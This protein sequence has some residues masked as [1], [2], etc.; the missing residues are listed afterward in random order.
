MPSPRSPRCL[1]VA[2]ALASP[3]AALAD[4]GAFEPS[5]GYTQPGTIPVNPWLVQNYNAGQTGGYTPIGPNTGLWR[6]NSTGTSG[7][8]LVST[9]GNH[10]PSGA[11]ALDL[12]GGNTSSIRS[13]AAVNGPSIDGDWTYTF[14]A[15]DLGVAPSSI[16]NNRVVT[17]SWYYRGGVGDVGDSTD[18][19][20]MGMFDSSSRGGVGF[21]LNDSS[22][23]IYRDAAGWHTTTQFMNGSVN[24]W[25]YVRVIMNLQ[26]DT[27]DI[28]V[29][30][31]VA[32]GMMISDGT[33][34]TTWLALGAI[35]GGGGMDD[36]TSMRLW[37]DSETA[38]A[39]AGTGVFGSNKSLLDDF[40][41]VVGET[42]PSPGAAAL[43][44]AVGAATAGR[45]R[46]ATCGRPDAVCR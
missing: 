40:R 39:G 15:A 16:N 29:T 36:L 7:Y 45:R 25:T 26:T 37:V 18:T 30:P 38:G 8:A 43:L 2:C 19:F 1:A 34:P 20:R 42:I 24:Q 44:A 5:N 3:A 14:D 27:F 6:E 21:G 12:R 32:P 35:M 13:G 4:L 31:G 28:G 33:A 10:T 9:D 46:R 22:Y 11:V 41:F 17:M 23:L